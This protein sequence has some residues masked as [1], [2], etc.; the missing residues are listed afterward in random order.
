MNAIATKELNQ[1]LIFIG[2]GV[3]IREI[4]R[5][6]SRSRIVRDMLVSSLAR[7]QLISAPVKSP[8]LDLIENV[9]ARRKNYVSASGLY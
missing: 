8:D 2:A 6:L 7:E 1:I 4:A 5:A 3:S 9:W